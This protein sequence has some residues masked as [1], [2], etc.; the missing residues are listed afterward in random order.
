MLIA[1]CME[2]QSELGML[3][4]TPVPPNTL[5]VYL[6]RGVSAIFGIEFITITRMIIASWIITDLWVI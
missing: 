4:G 6:E 2:R 1:Q 3:G 5:C